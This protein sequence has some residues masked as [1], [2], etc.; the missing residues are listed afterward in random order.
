MAKKGPIFN[1]M[2]GLG[3]G[4]CNKFSYL[5]LMASIIKNMNELIFT[6]LALWVVSVFF[7][8]RKR[9]LPVSSAQK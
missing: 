6:L 4:L 8:L 5:M 9:S 7:I 2:V 3:N 1:N